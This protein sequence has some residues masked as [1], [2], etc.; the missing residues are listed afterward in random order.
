MPKTKPSRPGAPVA[1]LKVD[2]SAAR[3][4]LL[5]RTGLGRAPGEAPRWAGSALEAVRALEYVQVD[6]M[7]V[8]ERNQDLVLGAR[9]EGYRPEVLDR[10][11]YVERRLVEVVARDRYIVPVEDYPLFSLRFKEIERENRPKLSAL[12][13]VM[14]A[15]LR[16]I[17]EEGALSSLDFEPSEKV[18]GWWDADGESRTRA[19]R[20]ALEWLWH[21]GRVAISRRE[22]NRR[23][24][25][26]PERL[27]GAD[28][29]GAPAARG[30]PGETASAPGEASGFT[31]D[32]RRALRDGLARKYFRAM[33][34]SDPRDVFF[35]WGH[36]KA[37]ERQAL[38]EEFVARGEIVPVAV[39]DSGT[40]YYAPAAEAGALAAAVDW[41]PVPEVRFLPPLDNLTWFRLRLADL[42][43]FDY[44]WEAYIPPAKRKYGPYTCP[45]LWGETFAGRI[46]ARVE[47]SGKPG[48]PTAARG[49]TGRQQN[50]TDNDRTPSALVVNGLW[51]EP[52]G[53]RPPH[54]VFLPA[55]ER[56]AVFNGARTIVDGKGVLRE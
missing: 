11:L 7:R 46:D 52:G 16:R 31:A 43:G 50:D 49:K 53:P 24:F 9:V 19:V 26:L 17:R 42:F 22:G 12:E 2:K 34:L 39:E 45:I 28:P 37:P 1:R 47:R 48:A 30:A 33:G 32:E 5:R 4:F 55:L 23:Y 27:F 20:Q 8:L 21:F 40:I 18:S 38:A 51:W 41:E 6:P 13:P 14:E 35:A 25:D 36:Y 56:W 54:E 10:L 44:T 3:R 29:V 15:V